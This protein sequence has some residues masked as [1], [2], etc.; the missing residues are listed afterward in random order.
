MNDR[1]VAQGGPKGSK[2]F[3]KAYPAALTWAIKGLDDDEYNKLE[4]LAKE[5]N[6]SGPP[7]DIKAR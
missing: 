5:W 6:I 7:A 3:L 1:A 4:D 2:E